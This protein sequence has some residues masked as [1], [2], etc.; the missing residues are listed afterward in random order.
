MRKFL[1]KYKVWV[2]PLFTILLMLTWATSGTGMGG[3]P[4]KRVVATLGGTKIRASEMLK[5]EEEFRALRDYLP[6]IVTMRVGVES[7]THWYLMALQ[8]ERAGLVGDKG[9]GQSWEEGLATEEARYEVMGNPQYRGIAEFLLNNPQMMTQFTQQT[10]QRMA[11]MRDRARGPLT[12]DDFGRALSRLRGVTRMI[13]AFQHAPRMSDVRMVGKV[14]DLSTRVSFDAL[15]IPAD[16]VKDV[17]EPTDATLRAMFEQYKGVKPGAGEY[18]LGYEEPK[19]VKVEWMTLSNAAIAAAVTLDAVEVN[20]HWRQN[21]ATFTGEF[22]A[23]RSNVEAALR[24][25]KVEAALTEA[26]RLIRA[27]IR[28]ATRN[29]DS[30]AGVK[31]LPDDWAT[32]RPSMEELARMVVAE[33]TSVRMPQPAVQVKAATFT[34]IE[35]FRSV[36]ELA[37]AQFRVGTQ[38]GGIVDFLGQT[39]EL[40]KSNSLGLQA[41]VP[42]EQPLTDAAGNRFY[43]TVL[44]AR[45]ES[46]AESLASVRD[47][48]VN[49]AKK[50]AA[51]EKLKAEAA[52]L[53]VQAITDGL[54]GLAKAFGTAGGAATDLTI[55]RRVVLTGEQMDRAY[56]QYDTE[57]V[58][59]AIEAQVD[60]LGHS[61]KASPENVAQRTV[62]VPLPA[63]QSLAIFQVTGHEPLSQEGMRTVTLQAARNLSGR[64]LFEQLR[65]EKTVNPFAF[66]TLKEEFAFIDLEQPAATAPEP[67]PASGESPANGG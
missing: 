6:G 44:E 57:Q 26:D 34:P 27:R 21:R 22:A 15:E 13:D 38:T 54:E 10:Q 42:F 17:A 2:L 5:A 31:R 56:S 59:E 64:D 25:A 19:R 35:E 36:G 23:E 29:L 63:R 47:R 4:G 49:D 48:V 41:G 18:G 9:D 66:Q 61:T 52:A 67:K 65:A 12:P 53:Q 11:M 1:R 37:S 40:S 51:F 7:G 30:A 46:P 8:A 14:G 32:R 28:S 33:V 50:L 39:Y 45:L 16:R 20:K 24:T 62:A 60:I 58:R 3:D 43:V 55:D